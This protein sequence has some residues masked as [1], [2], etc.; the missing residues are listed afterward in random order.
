MEQSLE[1]RQALAE[2]SLAKEC[3]SQMN[4]GNNL[5]SACR[6]ATEIASRLDQH[7]F[8]LNFSNIP[9]PSLRNVYSVYSVI[10]HLLYP[11]HSEN[12]LPLNPPQNEVQI[13]VQMNQNSSA[14]NVTIRAPIMDINFTNVRLSPLV[15]SLLQ[16][17]PDNTALDRIA[18]QI[19]PLFSQRKFI[20]SSRS[21]FSIL[22]KKTTLMLNSL[23]GIYK[24]HVFIIFQEGDL[25]NIT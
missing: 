9:T 11:F 22:I 19:S 13:S 20:L 15:A 23:Q 21:I 7:N 8:T 2:S 6:N 25:I 18:K 16:L 24:I 5:L 10:R 14:L 4:Q 3:E 12:I 1:L 17:N